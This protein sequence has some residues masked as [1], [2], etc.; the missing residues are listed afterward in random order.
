MRFSMDYQGT[1]MSGFIIE[2]DFSTPINEP[3]V[4]SE[5]GGIMVKENKVKLNDQEFTD[6]FVSEKKYPYIYFTER[7]GL[8][9]FKT[10]GMTWNL[11]N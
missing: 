11:V 10:S 7:E 8:V 4:K 1:S 2:K 5:L 9:G 3:Q 6:V